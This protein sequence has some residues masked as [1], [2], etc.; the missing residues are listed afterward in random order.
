MVFALVVPRAC[1]VFVG[2]GVPGTAS[3]LA[4]AV[5]AAS[6]ALVTRVPHV[7]AAALVFAACFCFF[8]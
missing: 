3:Q 5:R 6:V 1:F 2:D 8:C 4:R 7:M